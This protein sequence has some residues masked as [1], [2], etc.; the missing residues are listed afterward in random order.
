MDAM[1]GHPVGAAGAGWLAALVCLAGVTGCVERRFVITT[2]PPGAIVYDEKHLPLAAA[3]ADRQF[4]YYGTYRFTIVRDGYQTLVVDEHVRPPWYEIFPLDFVSEI[5]VPLTI[6]D[7]RRFHYSLQPAQLIPPESVLGEAM[8]LREKAKTIG[9]PLPPKAPRP[10][11][12]PAPRV[13]PDSQLPAPGVPGPQSGP[14]PAPGS[15]PP[16]LPPGTPLAPAPAAVPGTPPG[17]LPR[18]Q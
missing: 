3:P 2:D 6:S 9:V 11:E 17:S 13:L 12:G 8:P 1:K 14:V 10:V 18:T 4:T 5:L 16:A 15:P 7:V